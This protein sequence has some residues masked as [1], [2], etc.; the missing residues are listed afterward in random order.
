MK[1]KHRVPSALIDNATSTLTTTTTTLS[2]FRKSCS[3]DQRYVNSR[4]VIIVVLVHFYNISCC[5]DIYPSVFWLRSPGPILRSSPRMGNT[6]QDRCRDRGMCPKIVKFFLNIQY[7]RVLTEVAELSRR[8]KTSVFTGSGSLN[9]SNTS[10]SHL[11]T[12]FSQLPNLHTFISSS[13]LNSSQ[14]SLFIGRYS[15]SASFII[16]LIH[17]FLSISHSRLKTYLLHKSYLRIV[18]LLPPELPSRTIAWTVSSELR[19]FC[20]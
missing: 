7:T 20:F 17:K 18:S 9:A 11:P 12:K 15:C 3:L 8:A 1:V 10:S 19:S 2:S 4:L 5:W 14:Y 13:P 16:L 6:S